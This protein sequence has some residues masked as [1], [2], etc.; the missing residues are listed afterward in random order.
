MRR[1]RLWGMHGFAEWRTGVLVP[2]CGGAERDVKSP[3]S[4]DWRS[5]SA[6]ARP[7]AA[8]FS[9]AWRRSMRCVYARNAGRRDGFA[10]EEFISERKRSDGCDWRRA[11]PLHRISQDYQRNYG[12]W[13]RCGAGG[14]SL[15]LGA[16]VGSRLVRL[17]GK[18]KVDGTEIFGADET[19]AGALGCARDPV[20]ASPGAISASAISKRSSRTHPG[21]T[22]C[23]RRRMFPGKD[24]Y[25]VIPRFADQ[26]VFAH[27]R[28]AIPWRSDRGR[29]WRNGSA[30]KSL[31]LAEFPVRMGRV[32]AAQ[33]DR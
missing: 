3:P 2:G 8:I 16:A 14:V 22:P 25:G 20:P 24:C 21:V 27:E 19:P 9:S 10:R 12:L 1:R 29:G 6:A 13:A 18:G 5:A 32:A 17:D 28:S 11:L 4:R 26:P 23:S 33:N 7:L 30:A 15:R 31:D